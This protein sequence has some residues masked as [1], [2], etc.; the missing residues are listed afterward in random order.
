MMEARADTVSAP[1]GMITRQPPTLTG[2]VRRQ[3]GEGAIGLLLFLCAAVSILT[4]LGI[5]AVLVFEAIEFLQV[6]PITEFLLGTTWAPLFEPPSFGVLPLLAGTAIVSAIAMLIA[7]PTGLL[8]AIY[9]SEYA[10]RQ[11]RRGLKT[12]LE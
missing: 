7:L 11:A 12:M 4:T 2:A 6:V 10:S 8:A 3:I 9:L 1:T 5:V